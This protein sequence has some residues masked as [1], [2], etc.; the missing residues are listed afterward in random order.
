MTEPTQTPQ[1]LAP[2]QP[3]YTWQIPG[4]KQRARKRNLLIA[5]VIVLVLVAYAA[6]VMLHGR[7]S[8][9]VSITGC[10]TQTLLGQQVGVATLSVH[11]SGSASANY[12]ITV[13]FDSTDG[14]TQYGT[15]VAT[16]AGLAPG[17][18]STVSANGFQAGPSVVT[19][20]VISVARS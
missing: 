3:R 17:Q 4:A 10:G 11:N 15:A 18:S 1:P 5:G 16:V 8:D 19:C 6:W 20:K 2:I 9:D 12:V 13:A 14:S 7:T